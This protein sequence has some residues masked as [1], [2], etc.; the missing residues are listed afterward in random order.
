MD[1]QGLLREFGREYEVPG[2]FATEDPELFEIPLEEGLAV[3]LTTGDREFVLTS[4]FVD[5][6]EEGEEELYEQMMLA[7]L[8]GQGTSGGILAITENGK[9]IK[10]TKAIPNDVVYDDFRNGLEDF[11]N[12]VFFWRDEAKEASR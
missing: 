12:S 5:C 7:N 9:Q 6:P 10:L 8:F 1:L 4:T 3:Q 11:M 2:G